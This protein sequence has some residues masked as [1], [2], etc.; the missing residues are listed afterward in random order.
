MIG[1][2]ILHGRLAAVAAEMGERLRRTARSPAI[3]EQQA[4]ATAV[5][6][7]D[8]TLAA[9]H[10]SEPSHLYALRESVRQLFD[11]F[12]FDLAEGDVLAVADPFHGGTEPQT[13]TARRPALPRRLDRAVPRG[14]G[15]A[16][17][18]GRRVPRRDAPGSVRSLA[19]EHSGGR[20]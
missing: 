20:R 8:L 9:Q 10:Q 12:A 1:S 13:L 14:P 4:S 7:G 6:T 3:T 2:Q 19:G 15:A 17:R 16:R 5:F 18:S 11:Y